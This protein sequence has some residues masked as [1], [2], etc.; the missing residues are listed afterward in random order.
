[1]GGMGA[2]LLVLSER[3]ALVV[4]SPYG[5][6]VIDGGIVL[7]QEKVGM[8]LRELTAFDE[9]FENLPIG[10]QGTRLLLNDG[11]DG[12]RISVIHVG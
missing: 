9:A 6:I 8:V 10:G 7:A 11:H 12:G 2:R 4:H 3:V 1:M 5:V